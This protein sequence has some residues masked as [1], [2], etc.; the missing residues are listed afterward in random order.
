MPKKKKTKARARTQQAS[1]AADAADELLALQAIYGDELEVLPDGKS[2]SLV[3]VPHP[4]DGGVNRV[5]LRLVLRWLLV[6]AKTD[7]LEQQCLGVE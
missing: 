5:S 4:G 7:E 2:F 1:L 6:L 3:I